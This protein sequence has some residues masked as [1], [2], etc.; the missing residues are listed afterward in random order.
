MSQWWIPLRRVPFPYCRNVLLC[1]VERVGCYLPTPGLSRGG[2]GVRWSSWRRCLA[3]RWSRPERYGHLGRWSG[4]GH[5][6]GRVGGCRWM[7]V[8]IVGRGIGCCA[9]WGMALMCGW[10]GCGGGEGLV[11]I[12]GQRAIGC[13]CLWLPPVSSAFEKCCCETTVGRA[14]LG[15][16]CVL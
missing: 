1:R 10:T 12:G 4:C 6:D 2:D 8:G 16:C 5:G 14:R 3:R 11:H 7:I 13:S 15:S 9:R